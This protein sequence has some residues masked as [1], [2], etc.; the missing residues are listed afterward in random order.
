MAVR[1]VELLAVGKRADD[2]V[3][4]AVDGNARLVGVKAVHDGVA[5]RKS[6]TLGGQY[7][8]HVR[9]R[10]AFAWNR[11]LLFSAED[12]P[13]QTYGLASLFSLTVAVA[14]SA[15]VAAVAAPGPVVTTSTAPSPE[16]RYADVSRLFR[17]GRFAA[18]YG[19]AAALADGGHV[20]SAQLALVMHDQG[21]ALFGSDWFA[22]PDQR[23]RW[24]TL[25]VNAAR[26]RAEVPEGDGG[27]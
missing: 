25:V 18:A 12:I 6:A 1:I 8:R 20:P 22:S 23:R 11:D 13:M 7:A 14:A 27:D 5:G 3:I 2:E 21:R 19:R 24:N 26:Q 16:Q 17:E 10:R 15:V 4:G 9:I